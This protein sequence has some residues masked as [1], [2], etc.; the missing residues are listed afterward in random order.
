MYGTY[1]L[2]HQWV[3]TLSKNTKKDRPFLNYVHHST[4]GQTEGK[5]EEFAKEIYHVYVVYYDSI[6]YGNRLIPTSLC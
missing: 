3:R 4:L 6:I 2:Q 1:K 5:N